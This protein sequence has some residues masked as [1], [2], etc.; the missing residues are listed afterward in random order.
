M[1]IC[2]IIIDSNFDHVTKVVFTRFRHWEG[3]FNLYSMGLYMK[4]VFPVPWQFLPMALASING[5]A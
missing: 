3:T 4:T 1:S 5:L 2:P